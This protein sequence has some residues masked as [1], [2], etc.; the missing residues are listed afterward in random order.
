MPQTG[1]EEVDLF[2]AVC[3][4]FT[5]VLCGL[6]RVG[7][8]FSRSGGGD[9]RPQAVSRLHHLITCSLFKHLLY[10]T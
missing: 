2:D 6:R 5:S 9:G 7:C 1:G 3:D 10:N 8:C 4:I